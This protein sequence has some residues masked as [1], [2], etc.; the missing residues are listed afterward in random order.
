M[1]RAAITLAL[2][3]L[4]AGCASSMDAGIAHYT[5]KVFYDPAVGKEVCCVAEV[6]DGKNMKSITVHAAKTGEDDYSF[7]L[8]AQGVNGSTGQ[9]IASSTAT[10]ITT[11]VSS[12]AA[13]VVQIIHPL[14]LP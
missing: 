10:G 1:T 9:G 5:I 12:A 11:A 3:A 14:S 6:I 4:L 13:S 7:D 2:V 8:D